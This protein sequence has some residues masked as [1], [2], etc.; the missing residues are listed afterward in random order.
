MVP[1][2]CQAMID[3]MRVSSTPAPGAPRERVYHPMMSARSRRCNSALKSGL[4]TCAMP[5][6]SS[7]LRGILFHDTR[8]PQGPG[9][10][11]NRGF[12]DPPRGV[13]EGR[14]LHQH[15]ASQSGQVIEQS[16]LYGVSRDNRAIALLVASSGPIKLPAGT[17][18][19]VEASGFFSSLWRI[20]PGPC[21]SRPGR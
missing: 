6:A 3:H 16:V 21:R 20:R 12:F 7:I 4:T 10:R 17:Q 11:G 19:F 14:D 15:Q 5:F 1:L 8:H 13:A 2:A 9:S 18:V